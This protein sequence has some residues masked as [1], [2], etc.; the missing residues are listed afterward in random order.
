MTDVLLGPTRNPVLLAE[1]AASVDQL[2]AG[3]LTLGVGVGARHSRSSIVRGA[4]SSWRAPGIPLR[5]HRWTAGGA[6][7]S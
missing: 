5:P 2:S 3:R 7:S 6:S 4:A 1:E